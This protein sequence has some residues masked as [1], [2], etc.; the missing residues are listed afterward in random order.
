M[1]G[2]GVGREGEYDIFMCTELKP[3]LSIHFIFA[4]KH[5]SRAT[6]GFSASIY[7]YIYII[8]KYIHAYVFV[9]ECH[10]FPNSLRFFTDQSITIV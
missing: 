3:P 10:L 1:G 4:S 8:Y 6:P 9:F 5:E 7:I 2:G